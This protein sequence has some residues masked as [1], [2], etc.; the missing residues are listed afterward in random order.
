MI[1]KHQGLELRNSNFTVSFHLEAISDLF[2]Q[3]TNT[4]PGKELTWNPQE[5]PV[6]EQFLQLFFQ[7]VEEAMLF[8]FSVVNGHACI[9]LTI[10]LG[11][12]QLTTVL[13][14]GFGPTTLKRSGLSAQQD[15]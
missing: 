1:A 7:A 12:P 14:L 9:H 3:T 4:L 10:K 6:N 13:I 5:L 8:H 11:V 2:S 15:S